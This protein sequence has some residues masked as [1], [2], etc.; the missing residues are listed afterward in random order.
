MSVNTGHG[1]HCS[2][3]FQWSLHSSENA[4]TASL[5]SVSVSP[6]RLNTR[7]NTPKTAYSKKQFIIRFNNRQTKPM[8]HLGRK[9]VGK[10]KRLSRHMS[11]QG[12]PWGVGDIVIDRDRVQEAG[13][14]FNLGGVTCLLA[15]SLCYLYCLFHSFKT[16]KMHRINSL[17]C[18]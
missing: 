7:S 8:L 18:V 11:W 16:L 10:G 14:V 4:I 13:S 2:K 1:I 5:S 9:T 3:F 6:K 12:V 15:L 17:A